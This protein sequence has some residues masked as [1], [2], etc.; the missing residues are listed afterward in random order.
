MTAVVTYEYS[1]FAFQF[2]IAKPFASRVFGKSTSVTY[3]CIYAHLDRC[4]RRILHFVMTEFGSLTVSM[5]YWRAW[6]S[7]CSPLLFVALLSACSAPELRLVDGAEVATESGLVSGVSADDRVVRWLDIPYAQAPVGDLRWRAP[8]KLEENRAQRVITHDAQVLCPQM[9]SSTSGIGGDGPIGQEDSLY[10][11]IVA[12]A[13][14]RQKRYPVMVWVHGGGNTTGHKGTYDFTELAA[15]EQLV[16]VTFNYRLGPFGWMT[17]P[18]IQAGAQ[19]LDQSS[20]FGTLDIIAALEWTQRNIRDFGG[21]TSNVTLFGESAGGHNVYALLASPLGEGLFHRAIAQS[22]YTT[23][24]S[25][26]QAINHQREF[27]QIDRGSW[28]LTQALGLNVETVDAAVLRGI[29]MQ[30][31][32]GAYYGLD[33]DHLAPLTTADGIV[34]PSEGIAAALA[35]PSNSKKVPVL[36][37]SNRDEVTLW[38]GLNRYFVEGSN[39]SFGLLPPKVS[40]KNP[41]LYRYWIDIR[42][43]GWKARGVDAPLRALEGAGYAHLYAYRF[44]WDEQADNWL[45]PF[46]QLLGAAHGAE[47]AFVM[48]KPMYGPIG[49]YMYPDTPSAKTVT[50]RM[51]K[52]WG[53]FARTGEPGAVGG[54]P[55]PPYSSRAPHIMI[56]DSADQHGVTVDSQTLD[57][58]LQ[59]LS[60]RSPLSS[61]ERCLL[62]WELVVNIG[63]P[64]YDAYRRWNN[65]ECA[66]VDAPSEQ[67]AIQATL[68][69]AFGTTTIL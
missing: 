56:L 66:E 23:D 67:K 47:I 57:G 4:Q 65:G 19:G 61:L 46:S 33:K 69:E 20:N 48:G 64:Q 14:F 18:S 12:P 32:L 51:M 62:A 38:L 54:K 27:P 28:E 21:D 13:D 25:P 35:N 15:R 1:L 11:D 39:V 17:H 43:R 59:E 5:K 58:L 53:N 30:S 6:T 42:S 68:I 45:L 24:V 40:I 8:R 52:A 7:G 37:G 55:W 50:S 44:D 16:V 9:P 41:E 31:L 60:G 26:R 2:A 34:I 63:R 36:S 3:E 49:D 29:D 10:L 22:G